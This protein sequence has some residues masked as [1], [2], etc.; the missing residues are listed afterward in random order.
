MNTLEEDFTRFKNW[1]R[2]SVY[3]VKF[4]RICRFW[5]P[6]LDLLGWTLLAT[7]SFLNFA[8]M[9]IELKLY[10]FRML[11]GGSLVILFSRS[12]RYLFRDKYRRWELDRDRRLE[13]ESRQEELGEV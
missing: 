4:D 3:G 10:G 9:K 13:A 2:T 12:F 1:T 6:F 8:E 5:V 7:A 11:F